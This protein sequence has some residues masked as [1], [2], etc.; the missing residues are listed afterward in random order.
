MFSGKNNITPSLYESVD[1][2]K[3]TYCRL[4]VHVYPAWDY[5]DGDEEN[6]TNLIKQK[7]K[8]NPWGTGWVL[9]KLYPSQKL[10]SRDLR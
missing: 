10:W 1:W 9:R 2:L 5:I 6:S 8:K 3:G 4:V 7:K